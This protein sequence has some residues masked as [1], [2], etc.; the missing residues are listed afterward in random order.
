MPTLFFYCLLLLLSGCNNLYFYSPKTQESP[1]L[2]SQDP[3]YQDHWLSSQ[4]GNRLHLQ[5]HFADTR[6]D[7][8]VIHFHGNA[9]NLSE[10]GEKVLWL[11]EHGFDVLM[12]DYSGY[13]HSTG[14]A[15]SEALAQDAE[16]LLR[17]VSRNP[18]TRHKEITIIATSMGSAIALEGL[19]LTGL[20]NHFNQLLVDSS[21]D[22][23]SLLARDV[24]ADYPGGRLWRHLIPWFVDDRASPVHTAIQLKQLPVI[25]SHC[26][27]DRLIPYQRATGLYDSLHTNKQWWLLENCQ[28]ARGFTNDYPGYQ[29][30]L[31]F[32]LNMGNTDLFADS[33]SKS[34]EPT[35][36]TSDNSTSMG[37]DS[38]SSSQAK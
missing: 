37:N 17:F 2:A 19:A 21:F 36:T 11:L 25:I 7:R 4:S 22:L 13:G 16:T 3:G 26:R 9:G 12:F 18:M 35:R 10:T 24:V 1:L 27:D 31:L 15:T 33:E 32:R 6:S 8:L 34:S 5:Y 20:E 14:R 23:Y 29:Q 38:F 28:H 30:Q